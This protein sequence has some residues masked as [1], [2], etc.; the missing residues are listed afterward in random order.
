MKIF[1]TICGTISAVC[2]FVL[3]CGMEADLRLGFLIIPF[4]VFMYLSGGCYEEFYPRKWRKY[5]K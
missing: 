5:L 4:A 1:K 2:L 3:V